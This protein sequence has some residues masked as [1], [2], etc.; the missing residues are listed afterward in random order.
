MALIGDKDF[1]R[2]MRKM[3]NAQA[4]NK[5]GYSWCQTWGEEIIFYYLYLV[6]LWSMSYFEK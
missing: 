3:W 4:E 1:I 2:T 5:L 6:R